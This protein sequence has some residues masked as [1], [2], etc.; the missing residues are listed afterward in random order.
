MASPWAAELVKLRRAIHADPELSLSEE[1]TAAKVLDA[2]S[3]LGLEIRTDVAGHGIVADLKGAHPGPTLA[4]RADMDA[5]PIDEANEVDYCSR[6]QG[7]M[8]ACGHD[9]HTTIGVGVA[10][11][12][13][14]MQSDLHGTVRFIFQPAE[15]AAAPPGQVIGAESMCREGAIDGVEAIFGLH[16]L[17]SLDAGHFATSGMAVCAT[18]DIF[19]IRLHG[20]M[21]HGAYPH[22]GIDTVQMLAAII[23]PLLAIPNRV[24]DALNACVLSIG[25]VRAGKV[26]NIIPGEA[27][28]SGILR[29]FEDNARQ[30]AIEAI[31]RIVSG[32]AAAFGGTGEVSFTVG[33]KAVVNHPD[34]ERRVFEFFERSVGADA[35]TIERPHLGAEDFSAYSRRIP[36]CF[37][38]LGVR[39]LERGIIH[40]VHT[41]RFD[42]DER[43]I[44]FAVHHISQLIHELGQSWTPPGGS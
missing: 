15:E 39:N 24:T 22:R 18:S 43:C 7:V 12:L 3:S 29:T 38:W 8:H 40:P 41:P 1:R 42:V 36:A 9:V 20:A 16:V 30:A 28:L 2:I 11:Q 14:E 4:Y 6:N 31:E 33:A 27:E 37:F 26:H 17:P 19:D 21:S 10:R 34:V 13:A 25:R 23:P 32:T 5:L 44:P 35:L